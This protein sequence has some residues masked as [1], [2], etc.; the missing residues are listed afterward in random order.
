MLVV[1]DWHC[2]FL[3]LALDSV[4]TAKNRKQE[5]TNF[6]FYWFS[7]ESKHGVRNAGDCWMCDCVSTL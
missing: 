2:H 6:G 4:Y 1:P 7:G 3:Q 5:K